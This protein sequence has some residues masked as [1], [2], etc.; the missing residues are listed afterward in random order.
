MRGDEPAGLAFA[1]GRRVDVD[2]LAREPEL[3]QRIHASS[4]VRVSVR[5]SRYLT[6]TGVASDRPQ[7]LPGADRHRAR[8]GHDDRAF[9]HDERLAVGRL[10]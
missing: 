6:M 9:G 5:S 8:A 3:R 1:A 2:Q 7:S 10:G 4:S